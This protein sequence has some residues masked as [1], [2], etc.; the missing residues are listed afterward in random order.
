MPPDLNHFVKKTQLFKFYF[1]RQRAQ[2]VVQIV[3]EAGGID[4]V[5]SLYFLTVLNVQHS[6]CAVVQ[7]HLILHHAFGLF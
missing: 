6:K 1:E 5:L 4:Q 2:I 3:F 7:S